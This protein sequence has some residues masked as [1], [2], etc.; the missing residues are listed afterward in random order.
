MRMVQGSA[1]AQTLY[2]PISSVADPAVDAIVSSPGYTA[3]V[4]HLRP[5]IAADDDITG[6]SGKCGTF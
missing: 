4:E 5:Q 1:V 6:G 2:R 3:L